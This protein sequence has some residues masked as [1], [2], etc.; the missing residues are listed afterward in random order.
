MPRAAV[1]Q[2]CGHTLANMAM[3]RPCQA[4]ADNNGDFMTSEVITEQEALSRIDMLTRERDAATLRLCV[5]MR[6]PT[7]VQQEA[8]EERQ[9]AKFMQRPG[10][11]SGLAK[12][13]AAEKIADCRR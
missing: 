2:P 4:E 11:Q 5:E 7:P 6:W 8:D 12:V 10:I 9:L 1:L 13:E 3:P